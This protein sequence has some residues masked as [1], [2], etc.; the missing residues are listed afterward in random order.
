MPHAA[1]LLYVAALVVLVVPLNACSD[2][3]HYRVLL[4]RARELG[5][6]SPSKTPAPNVPPRAADAA[7]LA[8]LSSFEAQAQAGQGA[9]VQQRPKTTAKI[10]AARSVPM[11]SEMWVDAQ[12]ALS[13]LEAA[14][15]P[16]LIARGALDHLAIHAMATGSPGA[17]EIETTQKRVAALA[18]EQDSALQNLAENLFQS[19]TGSR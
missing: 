5:H 19:G 13:A 9:F 4:P 16:T 10:L 8:Q 1:R 12:Q 15:G 2:G 11:Q 18:D 17:L 14:R 3:G 7:L 6:A